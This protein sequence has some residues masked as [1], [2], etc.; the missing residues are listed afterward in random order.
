[1][2]KCTQQFEQVYLWEGGFLHMILRTRI[3][4]LNSYNEILQQMSKNKQN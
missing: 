1:M 2:K 4:D 3:L